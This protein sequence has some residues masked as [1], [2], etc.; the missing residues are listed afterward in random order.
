MSVCVGERMDIHWYIGDL[1]PTDKNLETNFGKHVKVL[2]K[3]GLSL[4]QSEVKSLMI[5]QDLVSF[6]FKDFTLFIGYFLVRL[7]CKIF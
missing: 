2:A 7:L 3:L 5:L 4:T 6:L 1:S